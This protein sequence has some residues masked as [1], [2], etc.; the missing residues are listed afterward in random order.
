MTMAGAGDN[1]SATIPGPGY[2]TIVYYYIWAADING[3]N[4]T[5]LNLSYVADSDPPGFDS[6]PTPPGANANQNI[7]ITADIDDLGGLSSVML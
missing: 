2:S 6:N 3:T 1:Y 5:S 4:A 7:T